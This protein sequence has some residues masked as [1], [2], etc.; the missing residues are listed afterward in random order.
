MRLDVFLK[1]SR[2]IKRR[3][4]ANEF[5]DK[6]RVL[7]GGNPAKAGREVK[8]GDVLT[9]KL[10][11]RRIVAEVVDIPKGNVPK[12]RSGELYKIIEDTALGEE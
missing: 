1:V 10:A 4:V 5:C 12:E 8:P 6:G 9:I 7:I 11:R 2:L 3:P